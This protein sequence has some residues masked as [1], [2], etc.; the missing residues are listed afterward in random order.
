MSDVVR[1][2]AAALLAAL[3]AVVVRKQVPELAI[4]LAVCGG[5]LILL[6]CSG[7]LEAAAELLDRLAELGG[8]SPQVLTP[9]VKTIGI[10]MVTRLASSLCRDAQESAL[11][12]VVELAGTA[13]ALAAVLP[14]MS[15][16]LDLLAQLL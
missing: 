3:C 9:M 2:A 16:V 6:Y 4:L 14:L 8:L 12:G 13:L 7:A 1:V 11:A 15:A 5:G 10:G